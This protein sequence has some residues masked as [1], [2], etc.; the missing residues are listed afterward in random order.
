PSSAAGPRLASSA[1][2]FQ[3]CSSTSPPCTPPS[4]HYS[5]PGQRSAPTTLHASMS[6]SRYA[7][8]SP[9]TTCCNGASPR[10]NGPS[11]AS[12]SSRSNRTATC[13]R[14][15]PVT[16][17]TP[18]STASASTRSATTAASGTRSPTSSPQSSS[19]PRSTAT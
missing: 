1:L 11:S 18:T 19:A 12:P 13:C 7:T 2:P 10:I 17:L 16:T 9:E 8:S 5:A 15:V 14:H 4:T 6:P 3:S